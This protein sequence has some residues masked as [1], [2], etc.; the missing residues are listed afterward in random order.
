MKYKKIKKICKLSHTFV[1]ITNNWYTYIFMNIE[2]FASQNVY[3]NKD[4]IQIKNDIV[5]MRSN[6]QKVQ[7]MFL[8]DLNHLKM[9]NCIGN[10]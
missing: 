2:T 9:Q 5:R 7:N 10:C 8:I 1:S 3:R 6:L 4:Q